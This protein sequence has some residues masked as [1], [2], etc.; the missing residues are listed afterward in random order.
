LYASR[1]RSAGDLIR[2]WRAEPQKRVSALWAAIRGTAAA[3]EVMF[4]REPLEQ[5]TQSGSAT[6]KI[7]STAKPLYTPQLRLA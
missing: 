1:W 7:F 3:Q 4:E 6:Q 2:L 5:E